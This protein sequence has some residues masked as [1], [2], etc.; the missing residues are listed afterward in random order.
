MA[1]WPWPWHFTP[2]NHCESTCRSNNGATGTRDDSL[3]A[4]PVALGETPEASAA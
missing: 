1:Q 2:P 4:A 3:P